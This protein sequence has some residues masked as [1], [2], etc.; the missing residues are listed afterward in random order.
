MNIQALEQ[1]SKTASL[2]DATDADLQT[3][4]QHLL[5]LL[6]DCDRLWVAMP[7]CPQMHGDYPVDPNWTESP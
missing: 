4:C 2:E 1:L 7:Q 3:I 6:N 5:E